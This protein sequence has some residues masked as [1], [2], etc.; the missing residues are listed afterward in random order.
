[1]KWWKRAIIVSVAAT[2]LFIG[3]GIFVTDVALKG[4]ITKEQDE[5]ISETVGQAVGGSVILTWVVC[6]M[7]RKR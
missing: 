3:A 6:L 2:V 7:R 5:K 1:M 4:K